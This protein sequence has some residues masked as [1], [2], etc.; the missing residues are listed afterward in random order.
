MPAGYNS[1]VLKYSK[2]GFVKP[3]I[4]I[5]VNEMLEM[6]QKSYFEMVRYCNMKSLFR[7][8]AYWLSVLMTK[9]KFLYDMN[10]K[11]DEEYHLEFE[12]QQYEYTEFPDSLFV[13]DEI[14][15]DEEELHKMHSQEELS[16]EEEEEETEGDTSDSDSS[17]D[18]KPAQMKGKEMPIEITVMTEEELMKA[19]R[20]NTEP[21]PV[22][23]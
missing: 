17:N 1:K 9:K 20:P 10:K 6:Y 8:L 2:A 22:P 21:E 11:T 16:E 3:V 7:E 19:T 18:G 4:P 15:Q 5:V 14:A 13:D 23:L 12:I